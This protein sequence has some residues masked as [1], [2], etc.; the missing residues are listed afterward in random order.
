MPQREK[1]VELE[2]ILK[3]NLI[4]RGKSLNWYTV[5]DPTMLHS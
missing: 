5:V 1:D 4:Q 2:H 3:A